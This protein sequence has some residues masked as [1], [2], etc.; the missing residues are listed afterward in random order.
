MTAVTGN[1]RHIH[2]EY[3]KGE[4]VATHTTKDESTIVWRQTRRTHGS[5][6]S[7]SP[8]QPG[9]EKR[10]SRPGCGGTAAS[11]SCP[12]PAELRSAECGEFGGVGDIVVWGGWGVRGI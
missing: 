8:P 12:C 10:P 3:K 9:R 1:A 6:S 7:S 2:D 4:H 5:S 11:T